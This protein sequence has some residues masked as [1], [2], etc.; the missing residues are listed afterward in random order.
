MR[1][2]T[3]ILWAALA[4]MAMPAGGQAWAAPEDFR[5]E[6]AGQ[7]VKAGEATVIK[8]RLV[9][10]P[11]GKPVLGAILIQPKLE[12]GEGHGAMTAPVK[13]AAAPPE[14][15]LYAVEARPGM[16]GEWVI[17]VAAKVPGETGTVRGRL[18]LNL[19]Q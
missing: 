12:M 18:A 11:D 10:V 9:H 8:L 17:S 1:R 7:P 4:A 16:S 14:P 15:G 13:I 5:L 3:T 6:A 2:S 19:V